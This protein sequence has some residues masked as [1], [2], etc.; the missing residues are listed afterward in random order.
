MATKRQ[1]NMATALATLLPHV[2]YADAQDIKEMAN[3]RHLRHLPPAISLKLCALTHVRHNYTDYDTL[4]DEGMDRDA[5]RYCVLPEMLDVL[6]QW[7]ML[8][9][10]DELMTDKG[11]EPLAPN[12]S[13]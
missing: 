9:T 11:Q 2:P 7:G 6:D 1:R 13:C 10:E 8:I 5:A 12:K 3:A 4:M